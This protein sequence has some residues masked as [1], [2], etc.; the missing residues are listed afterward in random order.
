VISKAIWIAVTD[1]RRMLRRRANI[2]FV[3]VFPMLLILVLGATFG[4][5]SKLRLGVVADRPGPL[6]TALIRQ[7]EKTPEL[8]VVRVASDSALLTMV[9]RGN[10]AAGVQIPAGY[11]SAIERGRT[12]TL[13]YLARP[14]VSS[15]QLAEAVRGA[16]GSQAAVLGAARFALAERSAASFGAALGEA[17]RASAGVPVI[18]VTRTTAGRAVFPASLGQFDEGAWTELLLFLFLTAMTGAVALIE[19]RRLGLPR[20]MLATPTAPG[21]LIAGETLGRLL[22]GLLQ[23]AVIIFGSALLFGV[24]WGQPIGVAA[25]VILFDLVAAGFGTFVGTLFGNEQQAMG[26]SLLLGLGLAALGGCMVPLEIFSPVM[27]RV[28]HV[29]PH[30]WANDAFAKLIGHGASIGVILPQLGVLAAYAAVL[31]VLST[32]RLR[33]VLVASG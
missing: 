23:A 21:V 2:F 14:G 25:V 8:R 22:I 32:W 27:K 33:R 7:L 30:A 10:L 3:F 9:Q 28:A 17:R 1:L 19:I 20:R 4:G 5:S 26:L 11:D 15:L 29:T 16:A 24:H 31:L 18:S 12:V 13:R 6:E